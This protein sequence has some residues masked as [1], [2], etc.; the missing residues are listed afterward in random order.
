MRTF[1]TRLNAHR[2]LVPIAGVLTTPLVPAAAGCPDPVAGQLPGVTGTLG[3]VIATT[4]WPN[5]I[6]ND[7]DVCEDAWVLRVEQD[8]WI[9]G[10]FAPNNGVPT[11]QTIMHF[12]IVLPG[13]YTEP[14]VSQWPVFANGASLR[15]YLLR[16]EP[17][18]VLA[19]RTG[20]VTFDK[21]VLGVM[22]SDA[23]FAQSP[24][25]Y[26]RNGVAYDSDPRVQV[27]MPEIGTYIELSADRRTVSFSARADG[28]YFD[29]IR[30]VTGS[31]NFCPNGGLVIGGVTSIGVDDQQ[32]DDK[33]IVIVGGELSV[34][35]DHQFASIVTQSI[36]TIGGGSPQP[37]PGVITHPVGG[38]DVGLTE[39]IGF[40]IT[41]LHDVYFGPDQAGADANPLARSG[42]DV[43]YVGY[44]HGSGPGVPGAHAGRSAAGAAPVYGSITQPTTMGSGGVL[45]TTCALS[46][47]HGGGAARLAVSGR[48]RLDG[49]IR[50]NG[51][52]GVRS[53]SY[54]CGNY[55]SGGAGGSVW[56]DAN[57]IE[58]SGVIQARG[59][60]A[61]PS[62]TWSGGGGGG[63][64]ALY[65]NDSSFAGQISAGSGEPTASDGGAGTIFIRDWDEPF[66]DLIVAAG[67]R[68][69]GATSIT[70]LPGNQHFRSVRLSD[71]A[72]VELTGPIETEGAIEIVRTARVTTLNQTPVF[73]FAGAEFTLDSTSVVDASGRGLAPT[74]SQQSG[75]SHG[76][77]GG[78]AP[79]VPLPGD[80]YEPSALGEAGGGLGSTAGT[81]GRGGG[82]V[83]L[84]SVAPMSIDGQILANGNGGTRGNY[85]WFYG[86]GGAG[87]SIWL[88]APEVSGSGVFHANGGGQGGSGGGGGGRIAV[89]A[90]ANTLIPGNFFVNGGSGSVPGQP[91]T[92]FAPGFGVAVLSQPSSETVCPNASLTLTCNFGMARTMQWYRNNVAVQ[93]GQTEWGS[94]ITGSQTSVLNISGVTEE[95]GGVYHAVGTN[96]CGIGTTELASVTV[97]LGQ[98]PICTGCAACAADYDQNGGVDG[99]D[100]AAFFADFEAGEACADVDNNGGVDGGDLAFFFAVFEAGG[101]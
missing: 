70:T 22:Y 17:G 61:H 79:L 37:V 7:R 51:H 54:L 82:A 11:A 49:S 93:D 95:D 52:Y 66:G 39:P 47:G 35:G 32:H 57:H 97:R 1:L 27:E 6:T 8:E 73:M 3:E 76:G 16:L 78:N 87:G 80:L 10:G 69:T 25:V 45:G 72:R 41:V 71:N 19:R 98:D 4:D 15:S 2:W 59:G 84:I 12:D 90:C 29:Q 24:L 101:C 88:E 30:I 92:L 89:H 31:D 46:Q 5:D 85:L 96:E 83:H 75:G 40:Q 43:S 58:G 56:I 50:A 64:I 44:Q 100:L 20:S 23:A 81:G 9:S 55:A 28:S 65:Y 18:A 99:G 26:Q 36:L 68:A 94:L 63:R 42:I 21:P 77:Y 13:T 74:R 38:T 67:N 53:G 86:G 91:G 33:C 48:L 14:P 62:G 60:G 34:A